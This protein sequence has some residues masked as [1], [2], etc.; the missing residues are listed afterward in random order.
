MAAAPLADEGSWKVSV[1]PFT[2]SCTG[3]L[4]ERQKGMEPGPTRFVKRQPVP[5]PHSRCFP[6]SV[7]P[8]IVPAMASTKVYL[9]ATFLLSSLS[10]PLVQAGPPR[11]S[12]SNPKSHSRFSKVD[13]DTSAVMC[14][15]T[16]LK[17]PPPARPAAVLRRNMCF[18]RVRAGES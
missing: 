2:P 5:E 7:L 4:E 13:D 11:W 17:E 1:S 16:A 12:C 15:A 9:A 6:Y 18:A 10:R 8:R 3:A 14:L